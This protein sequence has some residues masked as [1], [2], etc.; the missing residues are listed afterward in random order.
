MGQLGYSI[1]IISKLPKDR[2]GY[3]YQPQP[4]EIDS[5]K[6]NGIFEISG[7]DG[8]TVAIDVEGKVY[9]WGA[10]AC[11]QLGLAS[12]KDLP[13]DIE[14]Y[15]YQPTPRL[16]ELLENVH[17]QQ[18]SCG[19]AHTVALSKDGKLYSWGGGGCG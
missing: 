19:D 14:G 15:P 9:S 3:P 16:V 6:Q 17:I 10:S 7:G 12:M 1:K 18:I 13:T 5:L 2:E 4:F 8:H 11:G